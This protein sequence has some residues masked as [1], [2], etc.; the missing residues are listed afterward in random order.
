[1]SQKETTE[2]GAVYIQTQVARTKAVGNI[3]GVFHY[4]LSSSPPLSTLLLI[5]V[6]CLFFYTIK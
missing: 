1:M 4:I 3:D 6:G 2:N 5:F